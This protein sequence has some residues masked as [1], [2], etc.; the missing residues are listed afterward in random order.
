MVSEIRGSRGGNVRNQRVR[1]P[2]REERVQR[3]Q[4]RE[5]LRKSLTPDQ[6]LAILDQRLGKDV[7]A[8][9]ERARLTNLLLQAAESSKTKVKK[10]KE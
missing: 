9:R 5:A 10:A 8:V 2:R 4:E 3:A 1:H 6:Q 7:G